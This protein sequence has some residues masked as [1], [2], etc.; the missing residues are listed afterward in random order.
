[1]VNPRPVP[2]YLGLGT[3]LGD[4]RANL[5][6]AVTALASVARVQ[7]ASPVYQSK[8]WGVTD[9]PDFLNICLSATTLLPPVALLESLKAIEKSMG[10]EKKIHWGPRLIDIDILLYDTLTLESEILTIPHPYMA[11]RSF[12]MAPLADIA[13]GIIHPQTGKSIAD[14]LAEIDVSDSQKLAQPLFE[15]E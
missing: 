10:R 8:P 6:N 12:V 7:S 4:R 5:R 14:M 13:P 15:E 3:N 11:V 9:Q 1:M 2:V